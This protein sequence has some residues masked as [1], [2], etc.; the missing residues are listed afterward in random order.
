MGKNFTFLKNIY[1]SN[2]WE[3]NS[4]AKLI[5]CV[6]FKCNLK[7]K[8]CSIWKKDHREELSVGE[9]EKMFKKLP[10]LSWL[11]LTGGE[12]A[13]R[14]DLIDVIRTIITHSRNLKGFH[15]TSN[16]MLPEK[17][18]KAAQEVIRLKLKPVISISIDGPPEVHDLLRGHKGSYA[19]AIK[20]FTALKS[21][22]NS[23]THIS[24]TISKFNLKYIDEFVAALKK[25]VPRFSMKDLH[26]NFYHVSGHYYANETLG[27]KG[28]EGIGF[29]HIRKYFR[30][31]GGQNFIKNYLED[32]YLFY[33]E[34]YLNGEKISLACQAL[35]GS[36]F[37]PLFIL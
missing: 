28:K 22:K 34:K 26:F 14:E 11:D 9:I 29:S 13:L 27:E 23:D 36:V 3:L 25:D 15:M 5:F 8:I 32:K 20:T 4:I 6:T 24:C 18:I 2:T 33:L 19:Q 31:R 37:V 21:L 1:R 12:I 17:I 16:G 10:N 7:C 35:H 30:M